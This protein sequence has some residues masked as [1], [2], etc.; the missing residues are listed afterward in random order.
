MFNK[1]RGMLCNRLIPLHWWPG[2]PLS[3]TSTL[4]TFYMHALRELAYTMSAQLRGEG[5]NKKKINTDEGDG[6]QETS[7]VHFTCP[8]N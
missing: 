4:D 1:R 7:V 6:G 2:W 5:V 3:L 8:R